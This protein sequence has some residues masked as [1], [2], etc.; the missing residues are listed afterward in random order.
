MIKYFGREGREPA[1]VQV[2]GDPVLVKE[3]DLQ[4]LH[5]RLVQQAGQLR[6]TVCSFLLRE[7]L[8]TLCRSRSGSSAVPGAT[9]PTRC[10]PKKRRKEKGRGIKI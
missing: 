10:H 1:V 4:L 9:S 3:T 8:V 6:A 7:C 2:S 5:Q